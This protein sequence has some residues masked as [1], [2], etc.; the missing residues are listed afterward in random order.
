MCLVGD[1]VFVN[2]IDLAVVFCLLRCLLGIVVVWE[3]C[4]VWVVIVLV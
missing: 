4:C 2:Y 3:I 1:L